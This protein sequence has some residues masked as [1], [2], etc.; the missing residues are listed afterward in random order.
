MNKIRLFLTLT[1]Y[2]ITWLACVFGEVRFNQPLLG[3]YVGFIYLLIFFLFNKNKINFL[4]ISIYIS[5]P[6]YIFDTLMV[7]FLIY[8]FNSSLILGTIP[9][10]MLILWLSFSTLFD[11]V[12]LIFK[13]YKL[14][15][16]LLS[17][18]LGPV[19]YYIGNPIGIISINN[20]LLFFI[21]MIIFWIFLM[22]YY[23]NF[24]VNKSNFRAALF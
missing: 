20:V 16:I 10:W 9:I 5:I 21:F 24:I 1:G 18:I 22:I 4:K 11:E 3:I 15:G 8:E 13:D 19:T 14:I 2:Q 7:Y 6:G 23:L 12:L 17:G